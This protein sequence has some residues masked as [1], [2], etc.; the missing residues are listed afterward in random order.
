ME[1]PLR[2]ATPPAVLAA[3]LPEQAIAESKQW[4]AL[5]GYLGR[6]DRFQP[7]ARAI[8]GLASHQAAMMITSHQP[9]VWSGPIPA[10]RGSARRSGTAVP[11]PDGKVV[12][13]DRY[14]EIA[15]VTVTNTGDRPG[16]D[17]VQL[18]LTGPA[19]AGEPPYQLKGFQKVMLVPGRPRC[20]RSRSAD[21]T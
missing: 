13:A 8:S 1:A 7:T 10:K 3:D 19:S 17:V 2:L 18:Y 21:G 9:P 12:A 14:A 15:Q 5:Q 20:S 11:D 6:R 4:R 16:A